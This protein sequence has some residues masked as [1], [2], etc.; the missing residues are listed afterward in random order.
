MGAL[1]KRRLLVDTTRPGQLAGYIVVC[2]VNVK[3][4]DGTITHLT[5]LRYETWSKRAEDLAREL[6]GT[7][8]VERI[9][10]SEER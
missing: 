3:N 5:R 6:R 8:G 7:D 10:L 9:E 2:E 1:K 4:S